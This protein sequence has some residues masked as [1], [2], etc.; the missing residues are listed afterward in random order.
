MRLKITAATVHDADRIADIHMAAFGTNALLLA[1]FPTPNVRTQLRD[2][3]A[4][5]AAAD[6]RDPNIAVLVV[7]DQENQIISF[8]KW[9]LPVS[10][11][12][13]GQGLYVEA[14]WNWPEGTNFAVL[15]EW[16]ARMENAKQSVIGDR[17][18]YSE[19]SSILAQSCFF[20]S[21]LITSSILSVRVRCL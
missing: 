12:E 17:P 18:S 13:Q 14:P 11:T 6:I 2:C 1:Q 9:N 15:D 3:I 16:T 5:K 10:V 19:S 21:C 4:A 20:V 7:R 8:A